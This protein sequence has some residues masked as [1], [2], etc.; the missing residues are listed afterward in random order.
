MQ[1]FSFPLMFRM[2]EAE[3]GQAVRCVAQILL[4]ISF[5]ILVFWKV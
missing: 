1:N 3:T 5:W 2:F 4:D